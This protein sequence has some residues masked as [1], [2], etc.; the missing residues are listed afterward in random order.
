M[1]EENGTDKMK[2]L[3]SAVEKYIVGLDKIFFKRD[4]MRIVLLDV[5]L[6]MF[7]RELEE[8]D[9]FKEREGVKKVLFLEDKGVRYLLSLWNI[10][11]KYR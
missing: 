9:F 6:P 11:F 7:V 3:M 10:D 2:E 4:V 1:V 8:D 5:D